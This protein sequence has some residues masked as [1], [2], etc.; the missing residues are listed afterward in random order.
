MRFTW[1]VLACFAGF[2]TTVSAW[3]T[4]RPGSFSYNRDQFLL[5]GKPYQIIGGQMDPQ[6]IPPEYWTQRLK[7]ARAMGLNTIFSY[8]YWNL[9]EPS[10]GDWNFE[11]RNDV[12]QFFRLAQEEGLKVVLRPGPYICGERD[13]GGFPSWLSQVPGMAVR[14]NNGPFLAAAKSY[15]DRLGK[16]LGQLQVTQGGPILMAQL[17]NEYG[18]FGTDKVYLAALAKILRDNFDVFLY[19]NDGGGQSYLEGGQ[20]HGVLAVI[21]GD[22][23]SGFA[24][25]D[26]YV[27]DPTSLGPQLN[28][29]YYITWIDQWGSDYPHQQI[30][31]SE[32]AIADAIADLDWTLGGNYSFSIYMFHGGTNFGFENGGIRDN[33]PLAAVITSYDYG[34]PLDESGRPTDVYFRLRETISKYVAAG[35]I[36]GVPTLPARAAIPEFDL[37]PVASLFAIGCEA[38][39][40]A[41][42]PISM[43]AMGQSYGYVMYEHRVAKAISGN[44]TIGDGARDRAMIYVNGVRVGVVDT[45]YKVPATVRVT[46]K[47]GDTL[48][49]LVENLG[50]VDVRQRLR[51]QVK[52]IV[53]N[54]A[55]GGRIL[56]KWSTYS[57]P[58]STVPSSLSANSKGYTV[59]KNNS[60]V[61]YTGSFDLPKGASSGPDTDTFISVPKG[62][63]GVLWING[64]NMGRYW[65]IGPQQSLYVPG[66]FLKETNEVV[67]LELEPQPDVR[68][69]AEGISERKWFNSPDPDA[70]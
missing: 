48:Q 15:I 41:D 70:P 6:R 44:V 27:T 31:G 61:F 18:S 39:K 4:L 37:E 45:I 63:K 8:L 22:S 65:T 32:G 60:P 54:V 69:S 3:S 19:T 10:P 40:E 43:D 23:K 36:P 28:G 17:E 35:S 12:A 11:G 49:I 24:A 55:V 1:G 67:L 20:L 59:K 38:S 13:W 14:Q 57:I 9:I 42:N 53:G 66:S 56:R 7:M 2:S 26:K 47:E 50:R 5:N 68:L 29:E 25:R 34:A 33:G 30:S 58:L 46:L 51:D 16:E 21:D 64:I 62:V 52:G